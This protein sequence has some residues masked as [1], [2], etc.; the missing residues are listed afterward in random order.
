MLAD[1]GFAVGLLIVSAWIASWAILATILAS[2]RRVPTN[3][4]ALLGV[5]LGPLGLVAV[6]ALPRTSD[7]ERDSL[8]A[9]SP[10]SILE[11]ERLD[12]RLDGVDPFA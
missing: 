3:V 12:R 1:L 7:T 5:A 4:G 6:F 9:C 10:E 11:P 8:H 2:F